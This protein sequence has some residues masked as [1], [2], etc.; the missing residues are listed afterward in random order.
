MTQKDLEKWPDEALDQ[1]GYPTEEA[2]KFIEEYDVFEKKGVEDLVDFIGEIWYHGDWGFIRGGDK[3]ELHTGGWS[4][5]EDVIRSLEKTFFWD[6][7]LESYRRGGH[8]YFD[9]LNKFKK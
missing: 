5:N 1:D 2:L 6:F 7:C 8:Y 9:G 3:L 4:G